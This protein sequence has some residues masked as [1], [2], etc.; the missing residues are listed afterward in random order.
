MLAH[1]QRPDKP[2]DIRDVPICKTYCDE[3]FEACKNDMTCVEDW[4]DGKTQTVK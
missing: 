3:W 2:N 4:I 1:F